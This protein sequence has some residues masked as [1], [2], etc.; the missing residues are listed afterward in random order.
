MTCGRIAQ[1]NMLAQHLHA[2]GTRQTHIMYGIP[3][4]ILSGLFMGALLIILFQKPKVRRRIFSAHVAI[5]FSFNILVP[6]MW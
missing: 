2:N 3:I 5:L 6:L 4:N 1:W